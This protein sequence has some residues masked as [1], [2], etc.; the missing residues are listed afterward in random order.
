MPAE[1]TGRYKSI[2]WKDVAGMRDRLIHH[3][4]GVNLEMVWGVVETRLAD[5]EAVIQQESELLL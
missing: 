1:L 2:P 4:F 3:Y 5:L